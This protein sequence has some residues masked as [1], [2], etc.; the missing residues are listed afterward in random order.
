MHKIWQQLVNPWHA[1]QNFLGQ[2]SG[3]STIT[4]Y[5][6][7]WVIM[8]PIDIFN[9]C[10]LHSVA[11]K[12]ATYVGN[13]SPIAFLVLHTNI[14]DSK[15]NH[16]NLCNDNSL[17][18]HSWYDGSS[19]NLVHDAINMQTSIYCRVIYFDA[20]TDTYRTTKYLQAIIE[21]FKILKK[22]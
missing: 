12:L 13:I 19:S 2:K 21:K 1:N 7:P 3:T 16:A 17:L 14:H 9:Q 5:F 10:Q 18:T 11:C 15:Y 8:L 6:F 22:K 4:R 20:F